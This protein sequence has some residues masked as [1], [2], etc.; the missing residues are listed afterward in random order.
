M[1]QGKYDEAIEN[2]QI[3]LQLDPKLTRSYYNWGYALVLQGRYDEAIEHY[4]QAIQLDPTNS[5]GHKRLGNALTHQGKYDEA[6]KHFQQALQL[7]PTDAYGYYKLANILVKLERYDEAIKNYQAAMNLDPENLLAKMNFAEL[8][9][10]AGRFEKAFKLAQEVLGKPNISPEEIL[11]MR[12]ISISSLLFQEKR[13]TALVGLEN[14][15]EYYKFLPE[16]YER[17]LKYTKSKNFIRKT[18]KLSET[19][20][21][22]LL[23]LIDILES[24]TPQVDKKLK[25]LEALLAEAFEEPIIRT[26]FPQTH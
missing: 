26:I 23:T 14:Y 22:L 21:T 7:D 12:L 13:F 25:K 15:I 4:Q 18:E 2:F 10:R 16:D 19:D 17:N 3:A 6:I 24:P 1:H 20:K 5:Y 8:C 9:L 11:T